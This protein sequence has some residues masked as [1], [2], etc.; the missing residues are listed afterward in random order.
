MIVEAAGLSV[1]YTHA[2]GR[3]TLTAL[4]G[5]DLTVE[6]GDFFALLGLNGAGK[7]TAINC[8]LGLL[9]P[10]SGSV[11]VLGRTPNP[12]AALFRQ[13]GFLPEEPHYHEYLTVDEA[14]GYYGKLSGHSAWSDEASR[15][16]D[17]LGLGEFL[18]LR[19]AKCSKGIKQKL[20]IVQCLLGRPRL[21]FLDEPMRGL[22]PL[23]VREFRDELVNAN[24]QGA[25]IVM[26]SHILAEV[27]MVARRV[28]VL[29]RG[30][31]LAQ[32][33]LRDLVAIPDEAYVVEVE[34]CDALPEYF[35]RQA[36]STGTVEGLVPAE[37]FHDFLDFARGQHLK[38]L[39][40]ALRKAMLEDAFL[41]LVNHDHA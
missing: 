14:I 23:A 32:G 6:E 27:E 10:T 13:V 26:S 38:V 22:D 2:L 3:R 41:A 35:S 25:T 8:F 30:R 16:V 21:L 39:S 31:V 4:D 15:L 34:A 29:H 5:V 1:R 19:L 18:K 20:G 33:R 9:R 36:V 12:G 24:R 40:C 17:R 28:A 7:S 11:R 37:R